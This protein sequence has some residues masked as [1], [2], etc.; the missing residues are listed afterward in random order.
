[1][2]TRTKTATALF[3]AATIALLLTACDPGGAQNPNPVGQL[4]GSEEKSQA[5]ECD[6]A[7]GAAVDLIADAVGPDDTITAANTQKGDGGWYIGATIMPKGDDDTN[8]D[9]EEDAVSVWASTADPTADD[10]D[11]PLYAV[12]ETAQ[13]AVSDTA[14]TAAPSSFSDDSQLAQQV[15]NCV[16]GETDG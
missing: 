7:S 15:E 1:M 2:S 8:E 16:D 6:L 13:D 9:D 12:N 3:G 10:F 4:P 14:A 5:A 11:G